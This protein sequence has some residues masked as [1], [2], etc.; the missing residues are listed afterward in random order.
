[1]KD[2]FFEEILESFDDF[3]HYFDWNLLL[4]FPT[5]GQIIQ[6]IPIGA[7]FRNDVAMGLSFVYFVAL[8]DIR[9]VN[10]LQDLNLVVKHPQTLFAVLFEFDDLHSTL[11]V[12]LV[13]VPFVDFATVAW[14]DLLRDAIGVVA[15]F[16]IGLA[17]EGRV[18]TSEF[19]GGAHLF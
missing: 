18:V 12:V 5:S 14:A 15:H 3:G 19:A 13:A 4:Q 6:E 11:G 7:E 16:A 9:V 2:A 17:E 1:M 8:D 10:G